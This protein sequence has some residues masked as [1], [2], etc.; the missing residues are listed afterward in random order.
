MLAAFREE[1]ASP[2]FYD[3]RMQSI[4]T[5]TIS[6][7]VRIRATLSKKGAYAI[8]KAWSPTTRAL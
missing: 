5:V 7:I 6:I 4:N 3:N 1:I 2:D 8:E